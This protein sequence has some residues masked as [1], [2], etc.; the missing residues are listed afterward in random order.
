MKALIVAVLAL[1]GLVTPAAQASSSRALDQVV[2]S[3]RFKRLQEQ[4]RLPDADE[5]K[6]RITSNKEGFVTTYRIVLSY[7][8]TCSVVAV[9]AKKSFFNP[10]LKSSG[11]RRLERYSKPGL[12]LNGC[13]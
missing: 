10:N 7:S 12:A 4:A 1:S 3:K 11:P 2:N 13:E 8:E 5:A 6:V 9:I